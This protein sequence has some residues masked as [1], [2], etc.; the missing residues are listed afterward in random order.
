MTLATALKKNG[1]AADG[2]AEV[3]STSGPY[4]G[5]TSDYTLDSYG[6]VIRDMYILTVLNGEFRTVEMR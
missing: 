3:L 4:T 6:D 1:G 2:L 5:I